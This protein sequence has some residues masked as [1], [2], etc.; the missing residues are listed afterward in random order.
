[1]SLY[2]EWNADIDSIQTQEDYS[3]FWDNYLKVE[4]NIYKNIL[5]TKEN[6]LSGIVADLA[7]EYDATPKQFIGFLDGANTSFETEVDLEQLTEESEINCIIDFEKLLWNMHEAKADWLFKLKEWNGIMSEEKQKELAKKYNR[8]KQA[9]S[10]KIGR[11]DPCPCGSGKKYKNC[12][13]KN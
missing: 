5:S 11:N 7:K 3:N 9:V 13:G 8:S 2:S 12:C 6:L 10:N 1:M 4:T